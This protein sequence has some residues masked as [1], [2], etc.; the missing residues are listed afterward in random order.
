MIF[1][2]IAQYHTNPCDHPTS[3]HARGR[4]GGRPPVR[5]ATITA[6]RAMYADRNI[7]PAAIAKQLN[8][9]R[10]TVFKYAKLENLA[11]D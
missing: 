2:L 4:K 11:S 3:A 7:S 6:I 5:Q 9:H 8:I 10:A 1:T